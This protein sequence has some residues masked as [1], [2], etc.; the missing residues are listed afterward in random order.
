M[1]S[2]MHLMGVIHSALVLQKTDNTEVKMMDPPNYT[3]ATVIVTPSHCFVLASIIFTDFTQHHIKYALNKFSN[4][5]RQ[6]F[7]G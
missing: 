3:A 2:I 4:A 7:S 5:S 6:H 1:A